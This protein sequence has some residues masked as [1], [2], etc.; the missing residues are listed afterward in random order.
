MTPIFWQRLKTSRFPGV[1][2]V[3][4]RVVRRLLELLEIPSPEAQQWIRRITIMERH[5][6]LPVKAAG[7]VMIYSFY[8]TKWISAVHNELDL[9]VEAVQSFFWVYVGVNLVTACLLL[10]MGRLP[11]AHR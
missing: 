1:L 11:L 8:F 10:A 6:M 4:A 7:I 5:I 3:G 2:G 9:E